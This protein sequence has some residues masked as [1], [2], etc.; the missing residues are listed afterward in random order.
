MAKDLELRLVITAD[1]K[2]ALQ[3]LGAVASA[4]RA[5]GKAATAGADQTTQ[6]LEGITQAANGGL[7]TMLR[8][9]EGMELLGR[10]GDL[11]APLAKMADDWTNLQARLKIVT[12]ST[13]EYGQPA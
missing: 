7:V 6:A 13:Q 3:Q 8:F 2:V 4:E 1:G 9:N 12:G 10:A 5:V 11:L